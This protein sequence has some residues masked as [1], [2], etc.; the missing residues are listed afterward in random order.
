V[1]LVRGEGD[2]EALRASYISYVRD[3]SSYLFKMVELYYTQSFRELFMEGS[4]PLNIHKA[5]IS[6]LAGHVFPPSPP[7]QVR[8]RIR[9]F[10]LCVFLQQ[11]LPLGPRTSKFSIFDPSIDAA[12]SAAGQVQGSSGG[13]AVEGKPAK[14]EAVGSV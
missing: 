3:S 5:V 7:W 4:G 2:A 6:L 13:V 9:L 10:R 8:W 11:Y 14:T 1:S 12:S